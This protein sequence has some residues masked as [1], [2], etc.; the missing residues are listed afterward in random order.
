[1]IVAS[2]KLSQRPKRFVRARRIPFESGVSAGSPPK[3]RFTV[4]F[5]LTAMLFILFDIE[6]VFLYP[7]AVILH[8]LAW[9]GFAEFGVFVIVLAVAYVYIWR[10]GALEWR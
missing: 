5:Y 2:F 8:E 10:K 7:L 1:M 4:S 6:I 9:F 3:Q